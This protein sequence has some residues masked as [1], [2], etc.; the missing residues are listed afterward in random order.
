M[1]LIE[2]V[3][4]CKFVHIFGAYNFCFGHY[5]VTLGIKKIEKKNLVLTQNCTIVLTSVL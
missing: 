2:G 5:M 3:L 1:I 4:N